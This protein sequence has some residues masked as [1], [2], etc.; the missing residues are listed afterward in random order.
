MSAK[1]KVTQVS[2]AS[3]PVPTE[4][5]KEAF[6]SRYLATMNPGAEAEIAMLASSLAP[7]GSVFDAKASVSQAIAIREESSVAIRERRSALLAQANGH[8]LNALWYRIAA[9]RPESERAKDPHLSAIS[10]AMKKCNEEATK[11]WHEAPEREQERE[12]SEQLFVIAEG[13]SGVRPSLPCSVEAAIRWSI[14]DKENPMFSPWEMIEGAFIDFLS[15]LEAQEL[16]QKAL[17]PKWGSRPDA[18]RWV[19]LHRQALAHPDVKPEDAANHEKEISKYQ[20]II[21]ETDALGVYASKFEIRAKVPNSIGDHG[22]KA[23]ARRWRGKEAAEADLRFLS[24][25]FREFWQ[26]HSHAYLKRHDEAIKARKEEKALAK[27][28]NYQREEAG[29]A[30]AKARA[31]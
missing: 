2:G 10:E 17:D 8:C 1:S 25:G 13:K 7:R 6:V 5:E 16:H 19:E 23:Y 30:R 31:C 24:T 15:V 3:A 28:V 21:D 18:V 4:S 9:G 29:K 12:V 22:K 27:E 11:Q 20:A 26:Q 14:N